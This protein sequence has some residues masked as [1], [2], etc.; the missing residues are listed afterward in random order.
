MLLH[1]GMG[2]LG[3]AHLN[4]ARFYP[5]RFWTLDDLHAHA[6]D[7]A[8]INPDE[9]ILR[10]MRTQG[11]EVEHIDKHDLTIVYPKLRR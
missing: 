5:L 9:S 8:L 1:P 11:F 2:N 6:M 3:P 10:M 4:F 7:A